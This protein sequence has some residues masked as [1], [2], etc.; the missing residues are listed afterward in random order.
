ME[1][2]GAVFLGLLWGFLTGAIP[3]FTAIFKNHRIGLGIGGFVTCLLAGG[4]GGIILGL[5]C[6]AAF[7]YAIIRSASSSSPH[8]SP[9]A[10]GE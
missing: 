9:S 10:P 1:F 6:A 2:I 3:L 7:T 5:P 8:N 4:I